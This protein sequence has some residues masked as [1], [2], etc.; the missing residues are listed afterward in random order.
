MVMPRVPDVV[1]MTA[2][3]A[4]A[5]IAVVTIMAVPWIYDPVRITPVLQIAR[6]M[7]Y[8]LGL[9]LL[10]QERHNKCRAQERK[11]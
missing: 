2:A 4:P 10:R 9:C 11:E 5:D 7:D 6:G 3:W 1:V 8:R